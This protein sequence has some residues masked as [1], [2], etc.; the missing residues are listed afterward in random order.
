MADLPKGSKKLL[1][2]WAFYDWANS[3]YPL[4][5]S[6]AV[7]PIFY[8]A[9]F[10]D[11]NHYI[12][13]FGFS[14]KNSALISFVTAFA[15]LV[16]ALI[17]PLLSGI[18]DY[19]GNKKSFMK[20]FCYLGALSCVG[21]YWFNLENIYIGLLFYFLGLIGFW[22]SLVFYNSYLPDIAFVEQQD[23]TSARGY[24]YG[25]IGS[26]ILL[27]VNLGMIMM[28]DIFGITGTKGEAAMKAMR[29]SFIMV[30][31]W[32]IVFSQYTYY[33]LP[34]GSRNTE[35]KVTKALVFN[36]FRE[37]K[38]VWHLLE[39]NVALKKYL[40]S[41]FVY[42]MAVQTVMLIATYFGAQEIAWTS[43]SESTIG[44][45]ICILL[46]Q[47]VAIV[48]A[49]L[50]S[51]A[52]EKFGNIPTLIVINCFWVL[53]C[54][55]AYFITLPIHFYIM[56][57]LV[58]LV[59]GG[60]QALSR[61][62]Y[63]KLLPETEDTA[64]FFSFFDVSEKIGIVIGML[65]YGIIDQITGSPRFAIVFLGVFFIMGVILLKRVPKS[66]DK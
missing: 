64:S 19:V 13:V 34:K 27:I 32:W 57:G 46:I 7:F 21:L 15:F 14:V 11:R 49:V 10:S 9:L 50:T 30:G 45:I 33:Y 3:V 63:S 36:G 29:Y 66:N 24:S 38:K 51:K 47:I 6:S 17:S 54:A 16:V 62:T 4:V 12:T 23:K 55:A 42:S 39:E 41:F 8:E 26:V 48:G 20:F 31:I 1:N 35:R 37:L 58:G 52:S 59:M 56:A 2:A 5:I 28:P 40:I 22:G 43:K 65:V 53:L 25:Y 18:S 44:L 60:I 61:S